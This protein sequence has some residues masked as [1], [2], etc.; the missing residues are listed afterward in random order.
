LREGRQRVGQWVLSSTR[1]ALGFETRAALGYYNNE[2]GRWYAAKVSWLTERSTFVVGP[3]SVED[4]FR[5]SANPA[6]PS[7]CTADTPGRNRWS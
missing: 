6:A 1:A 3:I 5:A 2:N 4:R 7:A